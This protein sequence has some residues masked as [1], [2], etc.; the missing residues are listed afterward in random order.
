MS[1]NEYDTI[2][3]GAGHNALTTAAYLAKAGPS[4]IVLEA[5]RV[6]GGGTMPEELTGPG[7]RHDT[8]STGHPWLLTNPIYT[9]DELGIF[10]DGLAYV[11]NDPVAVFPFPDGES[12]T[13]W[14]DRHR[15]AAEIARFSP[16]DAETWV[17]HYDEWA[18]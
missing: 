5:R 6:I 16:K 7:L 1:T 8:F 9:A 10:R 13:V 3:I 4:V 15:T 17:R 12:I 2:V 11:G 14:R 18:E